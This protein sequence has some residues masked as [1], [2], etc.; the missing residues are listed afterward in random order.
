MVDPANI[1]QYD[2]T[3]A[4]L[5]EFLLFCCAVAGK[6][7]RQIASALDRFLSEADG[8]PFS[9]VRY[10]ALT[11][12]LEARIASSKLGQHYKLT[13]CFRELVS[14]GLDLREC[15]AQDLE[16]IYGIGPKTSRF[17]I[18][19]SRQNQRIAVLDTHILKWLRRLGHETPTAT[20]T[21]RKY[22]Q[23]ERVF[24]EEADKR[25]MNP[26]DLDLSIW[27]QYSRS[28]QHES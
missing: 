23:I 19:H 6:T 16:S 13:R 7:A 21:G 5:E 12:Q 24:L 27:R 4:E 11:G 2:R 15:T 22:A 14:A 1:T 9:H 18:L 3:D 28:A 10:L 8:P 17:F 25:N 26:A 20:P